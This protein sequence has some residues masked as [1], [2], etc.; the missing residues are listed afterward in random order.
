[1]K[2]IAISNISNGKET[3][4]LRILDLETKR[5]KDVPVDNVEWGFIGQ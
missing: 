3:I 2:L 5:I 4:G 1:M